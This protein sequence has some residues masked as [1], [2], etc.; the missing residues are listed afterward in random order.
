[1]KEISK[2]ALLSTVAFFAELLFIWLLIVHGASLVP[3]ISRD[4]PAFL[5]FMGLFG[6]IAPI[7]ALALLA[8]VSSG[9]MILSFISWISSRVGVWVM[10]VWTVVGIIGA[11]IGF[12]ML[13]GGYF[14]IIGDIS[15]SMWGMVIVAV[16]MLFFYAPAVFVMKA[17]QQDSSLP[18]EGEVVRS[19]IL[20][21]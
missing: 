16:T 19:P 2:L 12:V 6:I 4:A 5:H 3:E 21:T 14:E 13:F 17:L 18:L 8:L 10:R 15:V 9:V 1:M 11:I 20:T 7:L